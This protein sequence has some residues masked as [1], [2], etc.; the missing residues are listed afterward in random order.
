ML[1][2]PST[3]LWISV[4][5][6]DEMLRGQLTVVH[7]YRNTPCAVQEYAGLER[8]LT[9]MLRFNRLPYDEAADQIF[10]QIPSAVRQHHPN[11]CRIASIAISRGFVVVTRNLRHYALI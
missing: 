8:L 9:D 11:D 6:L 3:H 7:K 5:T 10:R 2:Q 4:V 1:S